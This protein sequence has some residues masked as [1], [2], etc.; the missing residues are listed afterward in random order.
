MHQDKKKMCQLRHT[1]V[2]TTILQYLLLNM[3]SYNTVLNFIHIYIFICNIYIYRY[4]LYTD[5]NIRLNCGK[6]DLTK[7]V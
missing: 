1:A 6:N 3:R 2:S 7:R 5:I 4:I